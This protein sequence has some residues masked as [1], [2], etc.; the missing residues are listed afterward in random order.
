[1]HHTFKLSLLMFLFLTGCNQAQPIHPLATST[2]LMKSTEEAVTTA[3]YTIQ[4]SQTAVDISTPILAPTQTFIPALPVAEAETKLRAVLQDNGGCK[5]PCF[6][7][8]TPGKSNT[9]DA[10]SFEHQFNSLV[11]DANGI[12]LSKEEV[13]LKMNL[14]ILGNKNESPSR[15]VQKIEVY[16]TAF[17]DEAKSDGFVYGNPYFN[18]Y[19]K[20]YTLQ[21]L[22]SNYGPP[23]NAYIGY[24]NQMGLENLYTLVL[25]YTSSGWIARFDMNIEE[26]VDPN[27]KTATG[28]P[29]KAFIT[30]YLWDPSDT[31]TR[32]YYAGNNFIEWIPIEKGTGLTLNHFYRQ[33]K[34]STNRKCLTTLTNIRP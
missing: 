15:R 31:T 29:D 11:P 6:F 33:F 10:W 16:F 23:E 1:M 27:P 18:E 30:L 17:T 12:V 4:P 9:V 20:Y 28:C 7:G 14:A 2:M 3:P 34:D 5:L 13:F 32:D 21:H 26:G 19:F 22:L 24:E 25:D 8:F